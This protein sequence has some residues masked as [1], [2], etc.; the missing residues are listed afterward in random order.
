MSYQ[1]FRVPGLEINKNG[2]AQLPHGRTSD[3]PASPKEGYVFVNEETN[4]IDVFINTKWISTE[5]MSLGAT[6]TGAGVAANSFRHPTDTT[7]AAFDLALDDTA[8]DGTRVEFFDAAGT[9]DDNNLTI[10]S[11]D[12]INGST[13]DLVLDTERGGISFIRQGGEWVQYGASGGGG[14]GSG[15]GIVDATVAKV[16]AVLVPGKSYLID[17]CEKIKFKDGNITKY[18]VEFARVVTGTVAMP[19]PIFDKVSVGAIDTTLPHYIVG[20][21]V[22]GR[23]AVSKKWVMFDGSDATAAGGYYMQLE[24]GIYDNP[25]SVLYW[26]ETTGAFDSGSVIDRNLAIDYVP[27]KFK[28]PAT[29][30]DDDS[31]YIADLW[32]SATGINFHVEINGEKFNASTEDLLF[33]SGNGALEAHYV[34]DFGWKLVRAM[35][36]MQGTV[37]VASATGGSNLFDVIGFTGAKVVTAVPAV[38]L[39]FGE[40]NIHTIHLDQDISMAAPDMGSIATGSWYVKFTED[41]AGAHRVTWDPVFHIHQGV[42]DHRADAVTM[43]SIVATGDGT[44]DVWLSPRP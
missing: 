32:G 11:G 12:K 28:L 7:A 15:I 4:R 14:G 23:H 21:L 33:N 39:K 18:N 17:N 25:A 37:D 8:P 6:L 3:R 43:A 19:S 42:F 44:Y 1:P 35:G 24:D 10:T 13:D 16:D 26:G 40:S 9:W 29:P 38:T 20:S 2:T 22:I 34:K 41:N 5:D 30:S 31:I 27:L 36:V